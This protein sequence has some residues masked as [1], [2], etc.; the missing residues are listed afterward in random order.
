MPDE[1]TTKAKDSLTR[2]YRELEE[3]EL[4]SKKEERELII[5]YLDTGDPA[6]KARVIRGALRFVIAEARKHPLS[7][8]NR[9]AMQ[10]LI[11]AGNIGLCRALD[12]FNPEAGTRF[13]TYAAWW[14]KHEMREAGRSA[15]VYSIPAHA[16]NRGVRPPVTVEITDY[17]N[18]YGG[19]DAS[20]QRIEDARSVV[21]LIEKANLSIREI[22][23]VKASFGI[24]TH[25]KTLRAIGNILSITGERVRQMRESALNKLRA[26]AAH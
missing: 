15:G 19:E 11:S 25:P 9:A 4:L 18:E 22:F 24:N 16:M 6:A 14:I 26:S 21:A 20:L 7:K 17:Q 13:L 10:D 2:Y 3:V 12:K 1:K 8:R 5:R 23:I